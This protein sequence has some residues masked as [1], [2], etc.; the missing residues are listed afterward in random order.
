MRMHLSDL[1]R[2]IAVAVMAFGEQRDRINVSDL[3]RLLKAPLV[4][5]FADPGDQAAGVEIEVNLTET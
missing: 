1:G 3:E 4:E 5:L 2:M